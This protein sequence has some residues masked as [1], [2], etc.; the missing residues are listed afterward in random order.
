MAY[1]YNVK[2]VGLDQIFDPYV[3]GTKAAITGYTV[4]IA[5]VDTDLRDIFAPLYLGTTA[6][7]TN[8]KVK[9]ADLNTF[10]AAKGTASYTLPFNGVTYTS[11]VNVIS[12]TG[13]AQ[14]GFRILSGTTYEIY[15]TNSL[16]GSTSYITGPIP[17]GAATVQY[18][19]GAYVV[20]PGF[21][22]AG[23]ATTNDAPT[24]TAV[25]SNPHVQYGTGGATATS[26][27][28]DRN[29]PLTVD[30]FNAGGSN[31]S[32]S[33]CHIVGETEGSV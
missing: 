16:G 26:G 4:K 22:D 30:F 3:S 29:Y 14:I 25:S 31:I 17:T 2:G 10:F 13:A 28:K 5:G 21:A 19:L 18:T 7:P 9:G 27:S 32:H 20:D 15:G 24:P 23:G 1:K 33:V 6:A 12:G 8:Y 11:S